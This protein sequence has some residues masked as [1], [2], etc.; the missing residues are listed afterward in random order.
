MQVE[1]DS[2]WAEAVLSGGSHPVDS[3]GFVD[4]L[5]PVLNR[6]HIGV[7]QSVAVPKVQRDACPRPVALQSRDTLRGICRF[8]LSSPT[9]SLRFSSHLLYYTPPAQSTLYFLDKMCNYV[10]ELDTFAARVRPLVVTVILLFIISGTLDRWVHQLV[11][12]VKDLW[13]VWLY[14]TVSAWISGCIAELL[15][16]YEPEFICE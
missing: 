9:D 7:G 14:F 4:V 6:A 2:L 1:H 10:L 5:D 13:F 16:P 15:F 11:N 12:T 3:H 8:G